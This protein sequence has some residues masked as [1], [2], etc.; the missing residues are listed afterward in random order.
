MINCFNKKNH[1]QF[2]F[3]FSSVTF[4]L[5]KW[6]SGESPI[7]TFYRSHQFSYT[8]LDEEGFGGRSY[9]CYRSHQLSYIS[10]DEVGF[11]WRCDTCLAKNKKKQTNKNTPKE[12]CYWSH[13][14]S[15]ISLDEVGFGWR[16][17]TRVTST[18]LHFSWWR[19]FQMRVWPLLW[20]HI[21][22]VT[23]NSPARFQVR[24]C[25]PLGV[26]LH[27]LD[28]ASS[29]IGFNKGNF[30]VCFFLSFF[31][32]SFSSPFCFLLILFFI[33]CHVLFVLFCLVF[34]KNWS[35]MWIMNLVS[36]LWTPQ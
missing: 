18:H 36:W 20:V 10:L 30:F 33:W 13:Q 12:T 14:L 1:N 32:F 26:K 27:S 23:L 7:Y 19:G 31:S 29:K 16:C 9:T 21:N 28:E 4:L 34:R 15:Y 3:W 11:R 8:S 35:Q 24:V 5:M 17:D 6:V 22:F 2:Q 25:S